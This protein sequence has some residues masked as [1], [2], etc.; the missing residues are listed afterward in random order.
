MKEIEGKKYISQD[1]LEEAI[2]SEIE[3]LTDTVSKYSKDKLK[4]GMLIIMF[5][6]SEFFTLRNKLV[7]GDTDENKQTN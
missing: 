5:V 3:F 2:K 1:E 6:M 4:D 7:K